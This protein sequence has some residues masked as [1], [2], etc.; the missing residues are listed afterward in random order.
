MEGT[1][2]SSIISHV[3]D[4]DTLQDQSCKKVQPNKSEGHDPRNSP[5]PEGQWTAEAGPQTHSLLHPSL[6]PLPSGGG[7]WALG[8]R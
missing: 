8:R 4:P 7:P 1:Q 3:H 2:G 6:R 5:T